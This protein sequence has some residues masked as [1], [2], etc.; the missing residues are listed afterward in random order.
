MRAQG[1]ILI[2]GTQAGEGCA[3]D[4]NGWYQRL[5]AWW[6]A[7]KAARRQARMAALEACWDTK[8]E[9]VRPLRAEAAAQGS[10]TVVSMLYGLSQ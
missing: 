7:Q 3:S 4:A 1:H 9:A 2:W 10:L 8:H 5:N 6:A